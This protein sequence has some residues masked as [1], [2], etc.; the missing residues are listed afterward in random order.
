MYQPATGIGRLLDRLAKGQPLT[1]P[2]ALITG[3]DA[4]NLR[5]VLADWWILIDEPLRARR[6]LGQVL[7]ERSP[8]TP[9]QKCYARMHLADLDFTAQHLEGFRAGYEL[10]L[11]DR[12]TNPWAARQHLVLAV[13]DYGRLQQQ[14]SALERFDRIQ[15]DFPAS[16]QARSAGWYRGV[17]FWW[18]GHWREAAAAWDDLDRR[19]PDHPWRSVLATDYRPR[20]AQAIAAKLPADAPPPPRPARPDPTNDEHPKDA[21]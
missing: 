21:P 14:R 9:D 17:I 4:I 1:D 12:P 15:R 3:R 6:I 7:A 5:L 13:D 20:L 10:A 19:Y 8:A 18:G 16:P 11:K 2:R